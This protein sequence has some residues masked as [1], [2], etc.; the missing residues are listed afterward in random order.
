MPIESCTP[1]EVGISASRLEQLAALSKTWI[2]PD[3]HQLILMQVLREGVSCFQHSVGNASP[4]PYLL[5]LGFDALVPVASL[6]KLFTA[7]AIMALVEDGWISLHNPVQDFIPEF[8]GKD[9]GQ[10]VPVALIDA[11]WRRYGH[12]RDGYFTVPKQP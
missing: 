1:E 11:Y 6:S 12:G 9:K 8:S 5:A 2:R 4:T 3:L 7:T 10:G